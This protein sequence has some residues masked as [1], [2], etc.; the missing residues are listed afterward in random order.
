M[1][2][3]ICVRRFIGLNLGKGDI[4]DNKRNVIDLIKDLGCDDIS[5]MICI[6]DC[7]KG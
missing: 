2:L 1:I 5:A 7:D 4:W 3:L 6:W